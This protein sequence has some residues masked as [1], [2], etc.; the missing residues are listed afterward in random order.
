MKIR[1]RIGFSNEEEDTRNSK[2]NI[3][4]FFFKFL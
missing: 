2:L 3:Y 1:W 4:E